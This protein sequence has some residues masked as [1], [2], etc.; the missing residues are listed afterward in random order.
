M[1]GYLVRCYGKQYSLYHDEAPTI[2]DG[3]TPAGELVDP[4]YPKK[5]PDRYARL[6]FK[7]IVGLDMAC[8]LED[9]EKAPKGA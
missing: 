6:S 4:G 7:A 5:I 1:S 3:R 2:K 8:Q 9:K